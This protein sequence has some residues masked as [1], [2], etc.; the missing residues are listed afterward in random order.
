M[1]ASDSGAARG[2]ADTPKYDPSRQGAAGAALL[3]DAKAYN[4]AA[5]VTADAGKEDKK[6]KKKKV[7]ASPCRTLAAHQ[8]L[9]SLLR[10]VMLFQLLF[11]PLSFH[12]HGC[13]GRFPKTMWATLDRTTVAEHWVGCL[14]RRSQR[15]LRRL[16]QWT[17]AL[18]QRMA[19]WR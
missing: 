16:L 17:A 6:A 5:D 4:P 19:R 15:V 14:C 2:K 18:Q 1:L 12:W 13:T 11:A 9:R 10:I 3:A 8:A 7:S